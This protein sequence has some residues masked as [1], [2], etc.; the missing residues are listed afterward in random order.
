[1]KCE[2]ITITISS[3]LDLIIRKMPV[4]L[5]IVFSQKWKTLFKSIQTQLQICPTIS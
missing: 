2:T 5:L 1:M 4:D 3:G